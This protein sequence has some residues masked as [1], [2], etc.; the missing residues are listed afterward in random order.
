MHQC[1][2]QT[3]NSN[4]LELLPAN[5]DKFCSLWTKAL[6]GPQN[7]NFADALFSDCCTDWCQTNTAKTVFAWC[8]ENACNGMKLLPK[9]PLPFI[10]VNRGWGSILLSHRFKYRCRKGWWWW[11]LQTAPRMS[12]NDSIL[13]EL[14]I[15]YT[16]PFMSHG[17]LLTCLSKLTYHTMVR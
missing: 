15:L 16:K 17:T 12:W 10:H 1:N 14:V 3:T 9:K 5:K 13:V 2:S 11:W 4:S 6:L 7:K 8:Y